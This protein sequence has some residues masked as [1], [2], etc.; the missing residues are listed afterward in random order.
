LRLRR[1]ER[2][3]AGR[4]SIRRSAPHRD[5]H[6]KIGAV[7]LEKQREDGGAREFAWDLTKVK[8]REVGDRA[9]IAP[10]TGQASCDLRSYVALRCG[11]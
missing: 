3:Y 1:A 2:G 7:D 4:R 5:K 11:P 9:G 8:Q 6:L 10:I